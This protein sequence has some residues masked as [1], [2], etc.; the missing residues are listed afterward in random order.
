MFK[1]S[2]RGEYEAAHQAA[3]K[4]MAKIS[5]ASSE[6]R[7]QKDSQAMSIVVVYNGFN[8]N[9]R[10]AVH[11]AIS[12]GDGN[13]VRPMIVRVEDHTPIRVG[14]TRPPKPRRV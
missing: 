2:K 13:V 10:D 5:D 4:M 12:G 1:K 6:F 9:G 7:R 3:L 14:G 11:T 8:G